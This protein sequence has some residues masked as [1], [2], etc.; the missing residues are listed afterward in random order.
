MRAQMVIEFADVLELRRGWIER[1]RPPCGHPR[2]ANEWYRAVDTGNDVCLVCG[3]ELP[4]ADG[5]N[6]T[7]R[8]SS[9]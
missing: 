2:L 6:E 5:S 9:N 1:G 3:E 4:R 8:D 7:A